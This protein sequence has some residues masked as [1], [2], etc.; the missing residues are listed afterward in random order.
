MVPASAFLLV[1][2]VVVGEAESLVG[3]LVVWLVVGEVQQAWL[4]VGEELVQQLKVQ[5][6]A[7][8]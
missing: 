7:G 4:V 2:A 1:V 6:L 8:V 5:W 3:Q